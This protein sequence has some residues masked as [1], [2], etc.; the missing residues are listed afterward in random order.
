VLHGPAAGLDAL[1]D[2]HLDDYQPYHAVRA[3]LLTRAERIQE[4]I[5]AYD[6]AIELTSNPAERDFL[7]RQ[8]QYAATNPSL[9]QP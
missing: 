9:S 8:R 4:A 1:A 6:R 7:N 2:V 5:T 3:D